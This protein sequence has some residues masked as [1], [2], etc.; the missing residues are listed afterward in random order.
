MKKIHSKKS[1]TKIILLAAGLVILAFGTYLL[2][3]RPEAL[4]QQDE[5]PLEP[6]PTID[7]NPPSQ[8]D[9]ED[10]IATKEQVA[11]RNKSGETTPAADNGTIQITSTTSSNNTYYVR[12]LISTVTS[13]GKCKLTM[14]RNDGKQYVASSDIQAMASS[15]TC[16]GFNIPSSSLGAGEWI[17]RVN[18]ERP[19]AP[20]IG[21]EKEVTI[22]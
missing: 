6:I 13:S 22:Q 4:F 21:V 11:E 9:I 3:T 2:A 16:M 14:T 5:T 15:S 20:T 7:Y 10:G 12:T 19:D 8:Q 18:I 1:S 17:I